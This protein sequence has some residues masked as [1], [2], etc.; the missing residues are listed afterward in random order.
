M[1]DIT[2]SDLCFL[3][4]SCDFLLQNYDLRKEARASEKEA[5]QRAKAVRSTVRPGVLFFGLGVRL[6]RGVG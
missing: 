3:P 4:R 2:H 5:L 6:S 1:F